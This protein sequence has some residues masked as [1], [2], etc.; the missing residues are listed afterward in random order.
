MVVIY[1]RAAQLVHSWAM[2]VFQHLLPASI[3]G[4]E[5]VIIFALF[6]AIRLNTYGSTHENLMALVFLSVGTICFFIFKRCI[7]LAAKVMR[8]SRDFSRIPFLQ[9]GSRFEHR[10]NV[11]LVSCRPLVLKVGDTFVITRDT[12][13]TISQD[14]ILTTLINLLITF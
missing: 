2:E 13:P 11:F 9:E 8:V 6:S 1:Y 5:T 14:I 12:F 10:D 3:A 7:E 4:A